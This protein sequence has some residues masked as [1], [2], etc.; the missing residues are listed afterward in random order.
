MSKLSDYKKQ[1]KL[2]NAEHVKEYQKKWHE[3]HPKKQKQ[4]NKRFIKL[5]PSYFKE[6]A[7]RRRAS[8]KYE[9][10]IVERLEQQMKLDETENFYQYYKN[11]TFDYLEKLI[12][13]LDKQKGK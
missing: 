11:N 3:E 12:N 4:Y 5:H 2:K 8:Q 1:W 10:P 9:H 6:Y 13:I 7:R